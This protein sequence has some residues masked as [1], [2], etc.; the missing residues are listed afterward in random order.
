MANFALIGAAGFVAPRHMKAIH[1]VGGRL[2]AALDPH[3]SV[4]VLDRY[5]PDC[6]FFTEFERFDRFCSR[7]AQNGNRIDYVVVASPNYLHDA[8]CRFGLRIG[9]D[10]ICEKPLVLYER[11]L[12]ELLH[13]EEETGK[14]IYTILQLRLS[15]AA[16]ALK[17]GLDG[18]GH[19]AT[20]RY[21]TPRGRWYAYS[22]KGDVRK[23]GGLCTNIGVH[24]FD[25][26]QWLFG[27]LDEI[28]ECRQNDQSVNGTLYFARG[29]AT[30]DLSID[31]MHRPLR[32]I[33]VDGEAMD[34][35]SGFT[36]LH[37][38]SYREILTGN[39]FGI[40]TARPA[41]TLCEALRRKLAL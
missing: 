33:T 25:L 1:D 38:E 28:G 17:K 34:M 13:L 27:D 6:R 32:H 5:F 12:D 10:V 41:V 36:N 19:T 15:L 39:G 14:R 30:F 3:D 2:V 23:S 40:E 37:T 4:G 11:N 29:Q 35:T 8:H 22:W 18:T 31:S 7:A 9:A 20:V 24:L 16:Q 21:H 26:L